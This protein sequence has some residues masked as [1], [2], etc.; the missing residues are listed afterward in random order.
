MHEKE[1]S[2]V[3]YSLEQI[4]NLLSFMGILKTYYNTNLL[5]FL[6]RMFHRNTKFMNCIYIKILERTKCYIASRILNSFI[7][8]EQLQSC[9]YSKCIWFHEKLNICSSVSAHS[10]C[11]FSTRAVWR[12]QLRTLFFFSQ[13]FIPIFVNQE[14]VWMKSDSMRV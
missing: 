12:S 7:S 4:W 10:W 13:S 5:I 3:K 1:L 14:I 2:T 6:K 11:L 8:L 9:L